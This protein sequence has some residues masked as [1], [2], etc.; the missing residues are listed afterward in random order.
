MGGG[1]GWGLDKAP[2]EPELPCLSEF[3]ENVTDFLFCTNHTWPYQITDNTAATDHRL[4]F[5]FYTNQSFLKSSKSRKQDLCQKFI[6]VPA[7]S[8]IFFRSFF[9]LKMH[10]LE[11][12]YLGGLCSTVLPS[13]L[14]LSVC[15]PSP[16]PPAHT[17]THTGWQVVVVRRKICVK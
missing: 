17:H 14:K 13:S 16:P 11:I 3:T 7:P 1:V 4:I 8:H 6:F 5:C 12:V 10:F 9:E 2:K 15:T